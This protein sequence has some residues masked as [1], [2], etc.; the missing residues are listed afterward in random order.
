MQRQK[1]QRA[2]ENRLFEAYSYRWKKE[3]RTGGW[4]EPEECFVLYTP[5]GKQTTPKEALAEIALLQAHIPGHPSTEWAK[6]MLSLPNIVMLDTETTGFGQDDEIIEIAL[7][8]VHQQRSYEKLVQCQQST[9]PPGAEK[10]HHISKSMLRDAPTWPQIWPKLMH[11]LSKREIIIYNADFDLRMLQQ[12]AQRYQ[13]TLPVLRVHCL[14]KH[15]SAYVRQP[16][17]HV[18]GYRF[19]SLAA[20]CAHFQVEH[21]SAHRALADA[22]A[23]AEVL[24][25]LAT[26]AQ[27]GN[28]GRR[29]EPSLDAP[30]IR[31]LLHE[32]NL[33][34]ENA[35]Q[36]LRTHGFTVAEDDERL[37]QCIQS[38][39]KESVSLAQALTAIEQKRLDDVAQRQREQKQ[40]RLEDF[41]N[42]VISLKE[43]LDLFGEAQN[44]ASAWGYSPFPQAKRLADGTIEV[45]TY[46]F[47]GE[48]RTALYK[49]EED[50]VNHLY[51]DGDGTW[52]PGAW[53][54]A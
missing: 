12:T 29:V 38:S 2:Q 50:V 54:Q 11:Y 16:S 8:D 40:K 51:S 45:T 18:E 9:I 23:A 10:K 37:L 4:G 41:K 26:L 21:P 27:P 22:Q 44:E 34:S 35:H 3:W 1:E 52:E 53:T 30:V 7:W 46:H 47:E 42:S 39:T 17:S 24:Q 36:F 20:A 13:L 15:Y 5:G 14:M 28:P 48:L 6:E 32:Y 43:T 25:K 19:L 49:T 31:L 33:A